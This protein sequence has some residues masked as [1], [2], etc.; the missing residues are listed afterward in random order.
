MYM[1]LHI[2]TDR[3]FDKALAF[4][5]KKEKATKSDIVRKLVME[6]YATTRREFLFGSLKTTEPPPGLPEILADLRDIDAD[7]NLD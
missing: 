5:A 3:D 2:T 7:S 1:A 6:R 4:L